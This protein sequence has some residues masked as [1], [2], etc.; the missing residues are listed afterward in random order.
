[1]NNLRTPLLSSCKNLPPYF[2]M[3]HLLHRLY[4]VRRPW[5][6]AMQCTIRQRRHFEC[7]S[8]R[9][10]WELLAVH[11]S[12]RLG[13]IFILCVC[14][15]E[16]MSLFMR[17]LLIIVFLIKMFPVAIPAFLLINGHRYAKVCVPVPLD[18]FHIRIIL[19]S[20]HKIF[21]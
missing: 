6:G 20:L 15:T 13:F 4:G 5:C 17:L 19:F 18:P 11:R 9:H 1:M 10:G 14:G 8:L 2:F 12:C 3:V 21:C 16:F 7:N